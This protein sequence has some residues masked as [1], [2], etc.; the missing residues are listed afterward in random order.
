MI[1][2]ILN[3][4]CYIAVFLLIACQTLDS[5]TSKRKPINWQSLKEKQLKSG[6]SLDAYTNVG[7]FSYQVYR[8]FN[9]PLSPTEILKVD[10]HWPDH[11]NQAPL[12]IF[13][14]GNGFNKEVHTEQAMHLASWGFYALTVEVP[15]RGQWLENGNRLAELVSL[16][17]AYPPLLNENIDIQNLILIGHSFGGSAVTIAASKNSHVK[18]LILLDPAVVSQSLFMTMKKVSI[19]VI[20]LGADP[21]VFQSR[22]RW[23]FFRYLGGSVAE[24]TVKGATHNDAQLPSIHKVN[25]GFDF[26]THENIQRRFLA[27]ITASVFSLTIGRNFSFLQKS[28]GRWVENGFLTQSKIRLAGAK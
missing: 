10:L 26:T 9:I 27:L 5:N 21:K 28:F 15:N 22:K 12:V 13:V 6:F 8:N 2:R 24:V 16:V 4:F 7:P 20:L 1:A 3:Q 25:W 19:P 11:A 17:Y 18:G 23:Q 14:H